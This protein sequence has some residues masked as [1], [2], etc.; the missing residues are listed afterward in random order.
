MATVGTNGN[1]LHYRLLPP[2]E[3]DRL[4][5]YFEFMGFFLPP[6]FLATAAVVENSEKQIVGFATLQLVLHAEPWWV[7]EKYAG[8]VN[9][10]RLWKLLEQIPSKKTNEALTPGFLLVAPDEKI[11]RMAE[12]GG[13]VQ[14]PGSLMRK[15]W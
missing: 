5:P 1:A 3:W 13:F 11:K 14:I 6:S 9:Y 8:L 15:E 7:D 4:K 12:L 10:I 2:A